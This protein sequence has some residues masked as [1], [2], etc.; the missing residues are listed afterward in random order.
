MEGKDLDKLRTEEFFSH[1]LALIRDSSRWQKYGKFIATALGAVPWVGTLLSL[2]TTWKADETQSS[3]NSLYEDWLTVHRE[4][5]GHLI[6]ALDEV[7]HRVEEVDQDLTQR[8]ESEEYLGLVRRAFRSW[9]V[10]ET[11]EKRRYL[12]NLITNAAATELSPDDMIR[13]FADWIDSYHEAHFKVIREIYQ[14][15]HSTRYDIWSSVSGALPRD[16]SAE[17]DLFKL[18]IRDL[19]TGSVIRQYRETNH[20][21][22][23]LEAKKKATRKGQASST[24][25]SAF[26]RTKEYVLTDLGSQFV[27]YTMNE[28]TTKI[29]QDRTSPGSW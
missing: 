28:V 17:A 8:V 3:I 2:R 18:L 12:V 27:H 5:V 4:K 24:L 29:E 19:S 20:H 9:D 21:G 23:F 1:D 22:E 10:A 6:E 16:D 7:A 14:K 26:E 15:P 13:L 25:E 11:D